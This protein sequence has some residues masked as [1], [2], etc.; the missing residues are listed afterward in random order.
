MSCIHANVFVQLRTKKIKI[1]S[2]RLIKRVKGPTSSDTAEHSMGV[3]AQSHRPIAVTSADKQHK[4]ML[5]R[6]ADCHFVS[7]LL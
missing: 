6:D 5:S 4:N 3:S 1:S 7:A 2:L